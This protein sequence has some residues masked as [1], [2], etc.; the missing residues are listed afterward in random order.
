MRL[1][2]LGYNF[3]QGLINIWKNK[4]FSLASIATMTACIFL[5]GLFY[6]I[7]VNFQAM[8][9]NAEEGVAITVFFNE[10]VTQDQIDGIGAM[11]ASRTDEV[12]DYKFVS[13]EEAWQTFQSDYFKGHEELAATF[14]NDNPMANSANYEVYVK[15]V[16]KQADLVA[17]IEG[18]DGVREVHHS[19]A[20]ASMLTDFNR[21]ISVISVGI[22]VLLVAVA[23]FLISDT[24]TVGI[25]V[26]KEEIAIMKLIGAK[27]TFVRAPFIVEGV[28]IG[29]IGAL[30]PLL[31]L[32]LL[33]QRIITYVATNFSALQMLIT[34]VP[35]NEIF[36]FLLP[37]SL[38]LGV[39]I[40]F[41]GSRMTLRRHL[42]V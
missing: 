8:V 22:V 17:F 4:M 42:K 24:V 14:A 37:M 1:S 2:T 18:L 40:G 16:S 39:G 27:D 10:G 3:R 15:D 31:L 23:V 9:H 20:A 6:A 19:E 30:I 21:L 38:I 13:A 28:V 33:Y 7:G 34:F 36:K 26:R 11:I 32:Y 35:L 25:S 12:A 29:F 41:V 5:L